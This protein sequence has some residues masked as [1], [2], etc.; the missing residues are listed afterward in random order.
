MSKTADPGA[1]S[2]TVEAFGAVI[3]IYDRMSPDFTNPRK[4]V[5]L[6]AFRGNRDRP[7]DPPRRLAVPSANR[8][9]ASGRARYSDAAGGA[10]APISGAGRHGRRDHRRRRAASAVGRASHRPDLADAQRSALG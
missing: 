4:P 5:K 2:T 1:R 10:G 7:D 9:A 6:T 8:A 3:P